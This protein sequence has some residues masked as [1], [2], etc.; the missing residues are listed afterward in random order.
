MNSQKKEFVVFDLEI[1]LSP[2][3]LARLWV[4]ECMRVFSDRLVD[5]GDCNISEDYE[6]LLLGI[7]VLR[8]P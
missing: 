3:H 6:L 8:N 4:H 5:E 7:H 1:A 2:V